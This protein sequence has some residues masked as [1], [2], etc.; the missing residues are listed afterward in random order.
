MIRVC[1]VCD[2][3]DLKIV[4]ESH[5]NL[6]V[7]TM[8]KLISGQTTV[9]FCDNC[10]H[11]QTDALND[12]KTYY[13]EEY[14]VNLNSTEE[15]QLYAIIDKIP[16]Y[17]SEHQANVLLKKVKLSNGTRVLD[18]GCAKSQTLKNVMAKNS[19]INPFF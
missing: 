10:G 8:N 18:Y 12:L 5:D 3:E 1:N 14:E 16:V 9:C 17:R 15:D 13:A 6:S 4:Y 7:T 11:L 19:N 2:K